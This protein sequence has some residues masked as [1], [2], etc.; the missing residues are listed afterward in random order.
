MSSGTIWFLREPSPEQ[1]TVTLL[2]LRNGR[3]VSLAAHPVPPGAFCLPASVHAVKVPG[4]RQRTE[5]PHLPQ[6]RLFGH[7]AQG[8]L[9][10][11]FSLFDVSFGKVPPTASP[12]HEDAPGAVFDDSAGGLHDGRVAEESFEGVSGVLRQYVEDVVI[13][14][15]LQQICGAQVGACAAANAGNVRFGITRFEYQC[16]IFVPDYLHGLLI[17]YKITH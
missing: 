14:E 16:F 11:A 4:R 13:V 12:H 9:F 3:F 7:F 5:Q 15:F 8:G 6:P 10:T 17:C 1:D 2:G